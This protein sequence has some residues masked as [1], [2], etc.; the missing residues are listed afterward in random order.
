MTT[1]KNL[2]NNLLKP[3]LDEWGEDEVRSSLEKLLMKSDG[4]RTKLYDGPKSHADQARKLTAVHAVE[5]LV[6]DDTR[7]KALSLIAARFDEKDFLRST[8]DVRQFII[9]AGER[10]PPMKNRQDSFRI[11]LGV[12]LRL[13]ADHLQQISNVASHA[14][15][16][17]LGPI[18]DAISA[19]G[20]RIPRWTGDTEQ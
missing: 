7:K 2:L 20:E 4:E 13:S 14:G 1:R 15:P 9:M 5:R 18:S 8:A 16:A 10:P 12:L 3:I 19:A 11:L 6:L 17:Q